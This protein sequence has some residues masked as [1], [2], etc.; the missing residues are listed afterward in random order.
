MHEKP[1]NDPY[2]TCFNTPKERLGLAICRVQQL[3]HDLG[4]EETLQIS[5]YGTFVVGDDGT[6]TPYM[7]KKGL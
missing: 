7:F 6:L 5:S 1:L 2:T 4:S 3:L